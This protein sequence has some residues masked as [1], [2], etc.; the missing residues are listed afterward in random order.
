MGQNEIHNTTFSAYSNNKFNLKAVDKMEIMW[1]DM[2]QQLYT[3]FIP[4]FTPI[5]SFV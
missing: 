2:T 4:K 1:T 3:H 5:L